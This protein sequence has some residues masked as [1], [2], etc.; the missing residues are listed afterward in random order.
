[1][2]GMTPEER[3]VY[4]AGQYG[5]M[6]TP[7]LNLMVGRMVSIV[8]GPTLVDGMV[9]VVLALWIDSGV[10]LELI[11]LGDFNP[12][13]IRNPPILVPDPGGDVERTSEDPITHVVTSTFYREDLDAALMQICYDA[14]ARFTGTGGLS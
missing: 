1:M 6:A 2:V 10:G 11:D 14:T 13:F 7:T 5:A 3:A 9:K 4:K 8:E 12:L